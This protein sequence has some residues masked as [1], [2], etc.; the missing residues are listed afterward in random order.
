[1]GSGAKWYEH[2]ASEDGGFATCGVA[3]LSMCL[4][5]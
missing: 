2:P 5:L 4:Y 3:D 1:M